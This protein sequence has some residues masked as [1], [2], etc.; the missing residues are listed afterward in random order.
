MNSANLHANI[1]KSPSHVHTDT[2]EWSYTCSWLEHSAHKQELISLPQRPPKQKIT[3]CFAAVRLM[4][5]EMTLAPETIVPRAI[6]QGMV[7]KADY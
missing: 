7:G 2:A 5:S 1:S 3:Y 6:L 4:P